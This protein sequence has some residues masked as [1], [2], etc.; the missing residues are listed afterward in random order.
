MSDRFNKQN[1]CMLTKFKEQLEKMETKN[2]VLFRKIVQKI[3][4]LKEME[5]SS[6]FAYLNSQNSKKF[7]S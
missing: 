7:F 6:L 4:Q 2:S 5:A 1:L 3:S